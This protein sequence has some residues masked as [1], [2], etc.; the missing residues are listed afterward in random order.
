M[1]NNYSVDVTTFLLQKQ[2]LFL[3]VTT[4]LGLKGHHQAKNYKIY[5]GEIN[6]YLFS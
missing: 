1:S 3:Q 5:E 6:G 4:P 2:Y